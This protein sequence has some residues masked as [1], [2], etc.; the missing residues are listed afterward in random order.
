MGPQWN[1]R[2]LLTFHFQGTLNQSTEIKA[3]LME[4]IVELR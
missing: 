4:N 2:E 3:S 1:I